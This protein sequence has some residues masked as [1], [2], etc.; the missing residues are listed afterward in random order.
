MRIAHVIDSMEVGGAEAVVTALCRMQQATG[1]SPEVHCVMKRGLLAERLEAEGVPVYLHGPS[2]EGR[3]MLSFY[4]GFKASRPDVVHCHN[5]VATVR[6][7]P[8]ARLA[9][10]GAVISTRHGMVAPPYRLRKE[11]KFWLTASMFCDRVVAV[12][13]TARGNMRTGAKAVAHKIV[14]IR[15]GAYSANG[16]S[17]VEVSKNGFTLVTVGRLAP[18][19]NYAMLLRSVAMARERVPDVSLWFVGD[20]VEAAS[21]KK[22]ADDLGLAGAVKFWGERGDVGPWLRKADVFVLSSLSEGLPISVLEA[23]AAGLPMIV[24]EVGGMPE[25]L[26]LSG[27]GRTVPPGDTQALGA[28]IVDLA[29]RR[30][31]LVDWGRRARACYEQYFTPERMASDYL[32]LYR[33]CLEARTAVA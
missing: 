5:K 11:L 2:G 23:M 6:A 30:K 13:E 28:T 16:G 26:S 33:T 3:A 14:T 18:A 10:A 15:N 4:R 1:H 25:V 12:C 17:P 24:T 22:L 29:A 19:K 31:E 21:L 27:A 7:A 9:G 32:S 8:A 20:G